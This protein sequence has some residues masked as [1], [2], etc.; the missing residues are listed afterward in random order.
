[1]INIRSLFNV[2]NREDTSKTSKFI[3][4]PLLRLTTAHVKISG[5][6]QQ[7]RII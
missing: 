4:R 2:C 6:F 1:M 5:L 7:L 3:D